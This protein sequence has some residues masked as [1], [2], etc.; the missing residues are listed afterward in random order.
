VPDP[1]GTCVAAIRPD[2]AGI[3]REHSELRFIWTG[4]RFEAA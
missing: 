4:E 1:G 2:A 3:P